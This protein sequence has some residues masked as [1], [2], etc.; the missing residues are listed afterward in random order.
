LI[1]H[2]AGG[3]S[4]AEAK[5]TLQVIAC[6]PFVVWGALPDALMQMCL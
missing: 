6:K 3:A 2:V 4:Q 5:E 1:L